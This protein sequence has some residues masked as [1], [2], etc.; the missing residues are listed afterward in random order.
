MHQT[1]ILAADDS[2][3]VR[4][5][6]NRTLSRAGFDVNLACDGLEAV[7]LA[8]HTLPDLV[9]LDIQMPGMNGYDACEEILALDHIGP[10]LPIVF[11]TKE[12]AHHLHT[13]GSQLGAYLP[14]PVCEATLLATVRNLLGFP[15]LENT[16]AGIC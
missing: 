13:L 9:I 14:K 7:L 16:C 2:R 3:T 12:T 10:V 1:R 5:V 15:T 4:T 11:L 6:V 8:K